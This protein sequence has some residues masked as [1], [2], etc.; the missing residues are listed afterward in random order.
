M[1]DKKMSTA[2]KVLI[3]LTLIVFGLFSISG[4]G[5]FAIFIMGS[6]VFMIVFSIV[7]PIASYEEYGSRRRT[8]YI[9]CFAISA[10][11]FVIGL[12]FFFDNHGGLG[13]ALFGLLLGGI[14]G[15]GF[16]STIITVVITEVS[17]K[18]SRSPEDEAG[19][20]KGDDKNG[21]K[22]PKAGAESR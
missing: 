12:M 8:V 19:Q 9:T 10:I 13:G 1:D 4:N 21:P 18:Y 16:I 2:A 3:G 15:F 14:G 20:H 5:W 22:N 7:N 11:I 6:G 17:I